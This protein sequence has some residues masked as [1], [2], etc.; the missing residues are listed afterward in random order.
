M[1]LMIHVYRD[2]GTENAIHTD[3]STGY[4]EPYSC[5]SSCFDLTLP[6]FNITTSTELA[7]DLFYSLVIGASVNIDIQFGLDLNPTFNSSIPRGVERLPSPF[8]KM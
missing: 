2:S 3:E 4:G 1:L 8:V 5:D 7:D 6:I